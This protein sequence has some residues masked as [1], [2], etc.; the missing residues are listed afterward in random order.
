MR[1]CDYCECEMC[2]TGIDSSVFADYHAQTSD[3]KFI[4]FTCY[5]YDLS[6]KEDNLC[7]DMNCEHRP[8]IIGK[9]IKQ[10]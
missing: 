8:T 2:K 3:L 10:T 5:K 1:F 6:V 4:C 9:W 7:E